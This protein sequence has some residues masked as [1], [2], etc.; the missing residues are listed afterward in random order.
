MTLCPIKQYSSMY[1]D[2]YD[3]QISVLRIIVSGYKCRNFQTKKIEEYVCM[4]KC[5]WKTIIIHK[6]RKQQS[7]QW[8]FFFFLPLPLIL[9]CS[10]FF[11]I[12]VFQHVCEQINFFL[13]G[14]LCEKREHLKNIFCYEI[15][16]RIV[17]NLEK[18]VLFIRTPPLNGLYC[19]SPE[20]GQNRLFSKRSVVTWCS[21]GWLLYCLV[22]SAYT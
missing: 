8:W 10:L 1:S 3:I 7:R 9:L 4:I 15:M 16:F 21:S 14:H 20:R 2:V 19:R 13:C 6:V 11:R 18:T 5:V 22:L 12:F 17:Y